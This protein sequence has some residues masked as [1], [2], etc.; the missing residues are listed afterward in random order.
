[1][2]TLTKFL[3]NTITAAPSAGPASVPGPPRATMRSVSTEVTSCT[4]T[5]LTKPLYQAQSTPAN[6]ANPPEIT[7]ARY[8]CS[9][10]S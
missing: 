6:P 1:M 7:K 9:Q 10:T 4:S 8:L 2:Y 5:G 3:R